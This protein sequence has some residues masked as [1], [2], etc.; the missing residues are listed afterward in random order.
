ML[1]LFSLEL[2]KEEDLEEEVEGMFRLED[3]SLDLRRLPSLALLLLS[4]EPE[5]GLILRKL[6]ELEAGLEPADSSSLLL[7]EP[8]SRKVESISP[9]LRKD[10]DPPP[11]LQDMARPELS[12]VLYLFVRENGSE[13][14][15]LNCG[16]FTLGGR[17]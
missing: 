1:S 11:G 9:D 7:A 6:V 15:S 5:L 13:R 3:R 16:V 4:P 2:L 12:F 17:R 14:T 8:L 10:P